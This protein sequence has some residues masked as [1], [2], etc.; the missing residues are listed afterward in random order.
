[1][2]NPPA[3]QEGAGNAG[4]FNLTHGPRA[5]KKHAAEP[6]V[7]ADPPAFPAQWLYGLYVLFPVTGLSCHRHLRIIIRRLDASVGASGPHD[8]AVRAGVARRFGAI[9]S[10][11]SRPAFRDD[12][13]TP[14]AG[15]GQYGGNY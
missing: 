7:Q 8:F 9:T 4:C 10:I 12:R 13:D 5:T 11:A 3:N 6:Q 15:V 2:I 1:L 14:L